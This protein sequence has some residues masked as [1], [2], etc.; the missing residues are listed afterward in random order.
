MSSNCAATDWCPE[1]CVPKTPETLIE[2]L[3]KSFDLK[4]KG[5]DNAEDGD[6]TPED[7]DNAYRWARYRL[8]KEMGF[9]W[10]RDPDHRTG[11]EWKR[12]SCHFEQKHCA[13]ADAPNVEPGLNDDPEVCNNKLYDIMQAS[14]H[15]CL[16]SRW[17]QDSA[18]KWNAYAMASAGL[19]PALVMGG[20]YGAM[21]YAGAVAVNA[22]ITSAYP[23]DPHKPGSRAQWT[24]SSE[25]ARYC[26]AVDAHP[27]WAEAR[28]SKMC[29]VSPHCEWR[30]TCSNESSKTC[31]RSA[32]CG[33][34]SHD[35]TRRC[36]SE[37]D[38]KTCK[39]S[40]TPCKADAQCPQPGDRCEANACEKGS[41]QGA[42]CEARESPRM[43]YTSFPNSWY[44]YGGGDGG[45]VTGVDVPLDDEDSCTEVG[46]AWDAT[47][48]KC[49]VDPIPQVVHECVYSQIGVPGKAYDLSNAETTVV[50][51]LAGVTLRPDRSFVVP[52][53]AGDR[54]PPG[55]SN[56]RIGFR[57]TANAS[58]A[59]GRGQ[60]YR[61]SARKEGTAMLVTVSPQNEPRWPSEE[62]ELKQGSLV[63]GE[64]RSISNETLLPA[65]VAQAE[66][67]CAAL[68]ARFENGLGCR[69]TMRTFKP[70]EI[71][72]NPS[73]AA[74]GLRDE[75]EGEGGTYIT[76]AIGYN[77]YRKSGTGPAQCVKGALN[78][79]KFCNFPTSRV[80]PDGED[81]FKPMEGF[82]EVPSWMYHGYMCD[83]E[84]GCKED[85]PGFGQTSELDEIFDFS[86]PDTPKWNKDK[87]WMCHA[88]NAY[89]QQKEVSWGKDPQGKDAA[90][91]YPGCYMDA[92][93]GV[94][95]T[96]FGS[97][98][99]RTFKRDIIENVNDSYDSCNNAGGG[100]V[101]GAALGSL[102]GAGTAVAGTLQFVGDVI[103]D[104][105]QSLGS[106]KFFG[107]IASV[108]CDRRLKAGAL[109]VRSDYL[110]PGVGLYR[111]EWNDEGARVGAGAAGAQ[112]FGFMADEVERAFEPGM[113]VAR[114]GYRAL[115]VVEAARR[116]RAADDPALAARLK[117]LQFWALNGP[118]LGEV[119]A[120]VFDEYSKRRFRE[121]SSALK[122]DAMPSTFYR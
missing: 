85:D 102:C 76:H 116:M 103:V 115:D 66:A 105:G 110:A 120:G 86:D 33:A 97:S 32:D 88:T 51:S 79:R 84:M 93:Q 61:Y 35:P 3:D 36:G 63:F 44:E 71:K 68:G 22:A 75:C 83:P 101:G 57:G 47:L 122:A 78:A 1:I 92:A 25:G 80:S 64:P 46:G 39:I 21:M 37:A 56:R 54:I 81:G 24:V 18:D 70:S 34:C 45:A 95:E 55:G 27:T 69:K 29:D 43:H 5:I 38:C 10:R 114:Q 17:Q 31:A 28:K 11:H 91:E 16:K 77:E 15:D 108:F 118:R 87:D 106:G 107:N 40:K 111:F 58:L 19:S 12:G 2:N 89:C 9:A 104:L 13:V 14:A 49:S 67:A 41:C 73:A 109:L 121:A 53:E 50:D 26:E 23:E 20:P 99:T 4:T 98:L 52:G 62:V 82:W 60:W 90:T 42:R 30:G 7:Y 113:V 96:I 119:A 65:E 74:I 48:F 117:G 100:G 112:S 72:A 6:F 8:C 59:N 94:F